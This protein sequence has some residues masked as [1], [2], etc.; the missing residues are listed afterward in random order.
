MPAIAAAGCHVIALL[1]LLELFNH[2]SSNLVSHSRFDFLYL[3]SNAL[4][5][6][7]VLSWFNLNVALLDASLVMLLFLD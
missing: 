5:L 7:L 3:V 2:M 6:A 4:C 1:W